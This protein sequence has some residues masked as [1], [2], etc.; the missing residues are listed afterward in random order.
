ME[1]CSLSKYQGAGLGLIVLFIGIFTI[2]IE[3]SFNHSLLN[4]KLLNIYLNF[5]YINIIY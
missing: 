1:Q 2:S 4:I 5:Y 3:F